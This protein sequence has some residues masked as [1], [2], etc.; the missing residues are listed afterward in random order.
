[1]QA[2]ESPFSFRNDAGVKVLLSPVASH[3]KRKSMVAH[4]FSSLA[5]YKILKNSLVKSKADA[6]AVTGK[7]SP[8][9]SQT[10]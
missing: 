10:R 4:V 9:E 3:N 7:D 8:R 6:L 1:M 2:T 5:I